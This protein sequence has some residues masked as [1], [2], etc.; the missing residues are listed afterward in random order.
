MRIAL[1]G[2]RLV[3]GRVALFMAMFMHLLGV[4]P[5]STPASCHPGALAV[6]EIPLRICL[7][8]CFGFIAFEHFFFFEDNFL[9]RH[10]LL[11]LLSF[12]RYVRART[13]THVHAHLKGF[14]R[15]APFLFLGRCE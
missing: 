1:S 15:L 3:H 10:S 7:E 12:T 2:G 14:R 9:L 4:A 8:P 5:L 13:V 11:S 6:L